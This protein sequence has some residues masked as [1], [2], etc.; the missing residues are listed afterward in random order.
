MLNHRVNTVIADDWCGVAEVVDSAI[1]GGITFDEL[2][3]QHNIHRPFTLYALTALSYYLTDWDREIDI[4]L[5]FL[6]VLVIYVLLISIVRNALPVWTPA[7]IIIAALL[8][9]S[10]RGRDFWVWA[11]LWSYLLSWLPILIAIWVIQRVPEGWVGWIV[12]VLM[13]LVA[14]YS[15]ASGWIAWFILPILLWAKGYRKP[16]YLIG[17][18]VCFAITFVVYFTGFQI[19]TEPLRTSCDIWVSAEGG[20]NL[21]TRLLA[22]TQ[23]FLSHLTAPFLSG[24]LED[25]D[26]ARIP[27]GILLIFIAINS[28]WWFRL[29]HRHKRCALMMPLILIMIYGLGSAVM[30]IYG[31]L[32]S[33]AVFNSGYQLH[34]AIFWVVFLTL[35]LSTSLMQLRD[36]RHKNRRL[37]LINIA[38]VIMLG[39]SYLYANNQAANLDTYPD[40]YQPYTHAGDIREDCF[41]SVPFAG[42]DCLF[43][44]EIAPQSPPQDIL[45]MSQHFAVARVN[46]FG[47]VTAMLPDVYHAGTPV[48]VAAA[49]AYQ[50]PRLGYRTGDGKVVSIPEIDVY[51]V[52][53]TTEL[54][55]L[56]EYVSQDHLILGDLADLNAVLALSGEV[57]LLSM[58]DPVGRNIRV[59]LESEN[60]TVTEWSNA[61]WRR[62]FDSVHRISIPETQ[63]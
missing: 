40:E 26:A 15:L 32:R 14:T 47:E 37:S 21:P 38:V 52:A 13:A 35:V 58:D 39:A 48:I 44:V 55:L 51:H 31:R 43:D 33:I 7:A 59:L 16:I 45:V 50:H 30:T 28:L 6:L 11:G 23:L 34:I 46:V 25:V 20:V 2:L 1:D 22:G 17:W 3:A 9:F 56:P 12:A 54:T 41:A 42:V 29:W 18:A 19:T 5:N 63:D 4:G 57:W 61:W 10:M 27:G 53:E 24:N 36:S 62:Q 60:F 8:L 49:P